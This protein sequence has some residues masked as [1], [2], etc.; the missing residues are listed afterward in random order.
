MLSLFHLLLL[1]LHQRAQYIRDY[2]MFVESRTEE[3]RCRDL[4]RMEHYFAEVIYNKDASRVED[5]I[6]IDSMDE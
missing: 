3:D 6:L 1:P 5:V 4:Y 2:G